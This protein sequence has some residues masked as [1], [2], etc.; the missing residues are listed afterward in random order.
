MVSVP[1]RS[2][3]D[4]PD[5]LK[6]RKPFFPRRHGPSEPKSFTVAE[7]DAG[8]ADAMALIEAEL[9]TPVEAPDTA[10]KGLA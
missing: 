1:R 10:A 8:R 6:Q 9:A 7:L 2:R 3:A 5:A 4:Q